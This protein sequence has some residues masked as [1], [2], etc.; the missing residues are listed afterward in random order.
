M[1]EKY[2]IDVVRLYVL[3]KAPPDLVLYWDERDIVGQ[4]RWL[5][6]LY[7][8]AIFYQNFPDNPDTTCAHMLRLQSS[9]ILSVTQSFEARQFHNAISFLIKFLNS[10]LSM[11][12]ISKTDLKASLSLFCRLL[13]PM[14]P[15]ISCEIWKILGIS[16]PIATAGWPRPTDHDSTHI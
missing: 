16:T 6:K 3:S 8:L 4:Q 5:T 13:Y 10:L 15:I 11:E 1:L 9:T 2:G 14:A 7:K 12:S